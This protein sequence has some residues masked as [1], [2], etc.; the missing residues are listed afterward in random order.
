VFSYEEVEHALGSLA[1][2]RY[3]ESEGDRWK[4]TSQ[5]LA[6]RE[7]LLGTRVCVVSGH[8]HIPRL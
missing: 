2:Q 7:T 3:V 1:E 6:I 5:G 4:A 8:E